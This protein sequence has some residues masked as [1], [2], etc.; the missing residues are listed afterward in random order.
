M[1]CVPLCLTLCKPTKLLCQWNFPGKDTGAGCHFLHEGIFLTQGSNP[2]LCVSCIGRWILYHC[3]IWEAL[4]CN[5]WVNSFGCVR[6]RVTWH[7]WLLPMDS[8]A[9]AHRLRSCCAW[10]LFFHCVWGLCSPSRN[11]PHVPCIGRWILNHWTIRGQS[12]P[13]LLEILVF[14]SRV[15]PLSWEVR[16]MHCLPVLPQC[17]RVQPTVAAW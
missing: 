15:N 17:S 1:C 7:L 8:L 13:L 5:S 10:A 2:H 9:V 12:L 4:K 3:A 16:V 6:S 14:V 11:I